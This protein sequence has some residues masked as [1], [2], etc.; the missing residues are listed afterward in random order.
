VNLIFFTHPDFESHQSMPRFAGMLAN[1][2][3]QRGH[4]VEIWS[5]LPK[6][7]KLPGSTSTKKWLG[8]IDQFI[9]F[10]IAVKRR[11]KK[12][13]VNSLFV[14]TDHA[15]GPW[16]PLVADLPHVIHCHDFLAQQSALGEI[17]ENPT[18]MSGRVYQRMIHRGYSVGK[19]FISVSL[20]TKAMLH[21]FLK[22]LPERSEVVYNGLNQSFRPSEVSSAR[23][24]VGKALNLDLNR[25]YILHVGGNQ[26]YKN[27][28]GV[29]KVYNAWRTR[30]GKILPLLLVGEVPNRGLE[31]IVAKS[32]YKSDIYCLTSVNDKILRDAYAG[33]S[34][35]VFP[36]KAEGFGWPI[37]E[38]MASGCPVVT[39]NEAPMTEVAGDA[40]FLIPRE[41]SDKSRVDAWAS[42]AAEKLDEVVRLSDQERAKAVATGLHNAKRFD[43]N[44]A[45]DRIEEIYKNILHEN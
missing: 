18:K 13:S 5:P 4:T 24:T 30:Q 23:D 9:L 37:A 33:A 12:V 35:F 22:A 31:E 11:L 41:P 26:W 40:G 43:T 8:Y 20:N 21:K 36:S 28:E 6:F 7:Y 44:A 14:F 45:L 16:I 3:K 27:R 2:M 19:N 17:P 39:T 1:G 42:T 29:V 34:V 38:A 32:P 10:P 25:G 15:L